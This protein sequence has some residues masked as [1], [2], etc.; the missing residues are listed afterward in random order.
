MS[1]FEHKRV[2]FDKILERYK[3]YC[4]L[5]VIM[6]NGSLDGVTE[7]EEFYWTWTYL[8]NKDEIHRPG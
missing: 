7:F 2:E 1:A 5:Y 6:N 3:A 4:E 8:S